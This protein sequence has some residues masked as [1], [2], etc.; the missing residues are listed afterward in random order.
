MAMT[1]R[2]ARVNADLTQR[3]A[4][5][6]IGVSAAM[7]VSWEKGRNYPTVDKLPKILDTYNVSYDDLNFLPRSSV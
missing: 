1:L 2:A 3:E 7:I 6:K 5:E 4:A